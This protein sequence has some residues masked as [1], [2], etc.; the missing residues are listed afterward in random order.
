MQASEEYGFYPHTRRG[1]DSFFA[2]S[3]AVATITIQEENTPV[4]LK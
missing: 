2:Y 4:K 1:F 3:T